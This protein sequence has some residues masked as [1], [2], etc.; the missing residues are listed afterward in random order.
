MKIEVTS[1]EP[2]GPED[3]QALPVVHFSGTSRSLDDAWDHNAH[4][5]LRGEHSMGKASIRLV[6]AKC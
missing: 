1:I 6:G 4:S 2:P 5:E 3:G